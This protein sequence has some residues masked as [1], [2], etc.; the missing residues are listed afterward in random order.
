MLFNPLIVNIY[1]LCLKG[2]FPIEET[3]EVMEKAKMQGKIKS[4]GVSN[5]A[6]NDKTSLLKMPNGRHC[7]TNQVHYNLGDRG[8]DYDLVP[9][10]KGH[11]MP[12]MAYAPIARG[13]CLGAELTKQKVLLDIAKKY[14]MDVF[15]IL[16]AWFIRNGKTIAIPKSSNRDHILNNVKAVNIRL[17]EDDLTKIDSVYPEPSVSEPIAL[18]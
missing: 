1:F 3:I 2:N 15:Q 13:G 8:I 12:L 6:V 4:W 10:M 16:L 17:T 7:A 9:L 18:W 14:Q 5:F 11:N